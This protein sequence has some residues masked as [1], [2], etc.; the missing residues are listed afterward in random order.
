MIE[1][2][3][4]TCFDPWDLKHMI[5][6]IE[7]T[8][9]EEHKIFQSNIP[10]C[11]ST[12]RN[13]CLQWALGDFLIMLDDDIEGFTHGWIDRLM[14]PMMCDPDI[15][16]VSALL[17]KPDRSI[18]E[19]C[20]GQFDVSAGWCYLHGNGPCMMPTAAMAIRNTG[21]MFDENYIGSGWEDNDWF[22][23][24]RRKF[25]QSKFAQSDEPL[26][27]RNEMKNQVAF[28]NVNRRYFYEKWGQNASHQT[29]S[30]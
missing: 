18:G 22:M 2:L 19:T 14:G 1:I 12:N 6:E 27:H 29:S 16:A 11:A 3:I 7:A 4:P 24:L 25:P 20:A 26:V 23:S 9:P 28:Y 15:L 8:T 10:A 21:V 30:H 17:L 5:Q 13:A